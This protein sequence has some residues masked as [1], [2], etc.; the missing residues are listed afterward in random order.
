MITKIKRLYEKVRDAIW[1][2]PKP[3]YRDHR[4]AEAEETARDYEEVLE[5][6]RRENPNGIRLYDLDRG[7]TTKEGVYDERRKDEKT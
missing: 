6:F 7:S 2:T 1:L 5:R 4:Q 3:K